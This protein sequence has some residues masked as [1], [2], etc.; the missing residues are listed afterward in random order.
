MPREKLYLQDI[1]ESVDAIERFLKN[2]SKDDF[3]EN[4]LVQSAVL[5]KLAVLG[6][7][8]A[9]ISDELKNRYPNIP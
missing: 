8:S 2:V 6:E 7:A 3:L 5:Q 9:R 4:Q 1:I